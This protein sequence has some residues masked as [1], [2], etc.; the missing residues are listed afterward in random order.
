MRAYISEQQMQATFAY[1][2][3]CDKVLDKAE[4]FK[5]NV[6]E[7]VINDYEKLM[8]ILRGL[9]IPNDDTKEEHHAGGDDTQT[10]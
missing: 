10:D 5:S 1:L 7:T 3:A 9:V 6:V 2:G 4:W 8:T